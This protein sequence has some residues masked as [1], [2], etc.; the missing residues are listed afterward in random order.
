MS[1]N[2]PDK[3]P[4]PFADVGLKNTIPDSSDNINGL[5]G[6]NQGFPPI[7]MT[8]KTAGGIPPFGQDMNGI[9]FAIT[10]CLR[11]FQ[12]GSI[13]A[14][15]STFSTTVGGYRAGASV[16]RA[17][18]AGRWLNITDGN[19]SDPESAGAAAAGWV[20][21]FTYGI[22][23]VTMTN[24]NVTLT[25]AQYGKPL[26]VITGL[27]TGNLNLIFPEIV[28]DW[29]VVNN[30]TGSFTITCKT[31]SGTGGLVT[32]GGSPQQFYGDGENLM[33]FNVSIATSGIVGSSRNVRMSCVS[34]SPTAN[35]TADEVTVQSALGG[36]VATLASINKTIN[37]ASTGAGGMDTGVAPANGFIGIYLIYNPSIS[38]SNLLG[39]NASSLLPEI[40]GGANIPSGYTMSALLAV[41]PVHTVNNQ[42]ATSLTVGR[43]T[44]RSNILVASGLS[45][46]TY[47]TI[48]A[49]S[50]VPRNGKKV[51]GSIY[52]I[53]NASAAGGVSVASDSLGTGAV[54]GLSSG[55]TG[56]GGGCAF[57][58]ETT[59][60][61]TFY[62]SASNTTASEVLVS[63]YE[64]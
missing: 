54:T 4:V 7:N 43:K 38:A 17:D 19:V 11:Y 32:Q 63:A 35:L 16:L 62:A 61:S 24:A 55:G 3:M 5:A 29:V 49:T 18:G 26:I 41:I 20:P 28:G 1:V 6:Y 45:V 56:F 21:D 50:V 60:G 42:F 14:Y 33:P 37:L 30:T 2:V 9:L 22:G 51:F 57:L 15:D 59:V 52:W 34:A 39:V 53:Q 64:I 27:L 31:A 58:I 8:P 36:G 10:E 25:P 47:T 48:N 23:A 13:Y 46:G 12:A 44:L 40:Y